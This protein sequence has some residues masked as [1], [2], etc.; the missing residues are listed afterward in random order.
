MP[1]GNTR[2]STKEIK[3]IPIVRFALIMAAVT[4]VLAFIFALIFALPMGMMAVIPRET[5]PF[6]GYP[7]SPLVFG[8]FAIIMWP[9]FAF[10]IGFISYAIFALIYNFLAPKIGGIRL[11]LE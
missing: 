2:A 3:S 8:F 4:A 10:V 11:E 5:M 6:W 9:L 1:K 7:W